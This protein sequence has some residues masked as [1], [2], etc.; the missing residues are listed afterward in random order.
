MGNTNLW[1]NNKKKHLWLADKI[2]FN[3]MQIY[4][5]I[6]NL[7]AC[8]FDFDRSFVYTNYL[9]RLEIIK[10]NDKF[11]NHA[12][13]T[14]CSKSFIFWSLKVISMFL[15]MR[16]YS[17]MLV[18]LSNLHTGVLILS[19]RECVSSSLTN[20]HLLHLKKCTFSV[21]LNSPFMLLAFLH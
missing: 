6:K 5:L 15:F 2:V 14:F 16:C 3:H 8:W 19:T 18:N 17:C 11:R 7:W 9:I 12:T 21:S 20:V 10:K 13:T 1:R 4:L